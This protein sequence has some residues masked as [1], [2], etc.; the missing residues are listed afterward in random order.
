MAELLFAKLRRCKASSQQQDHWRIAAMLGSIIGIVTL[1]SQ[2]SP[3]GSDD[4]SVLRLW[5][6]RRSVIMF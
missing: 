4:A 3:K 1:S 6:Q 5:M 2:S